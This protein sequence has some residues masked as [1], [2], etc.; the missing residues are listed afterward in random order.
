MQI[1]AVIECARA[2]VFYGRRNDN[3]FHTLAVVLKNCAAADPCDAVRNDNRAGNACDVN[4]IL[5]DDDKC[6]V[7]F[8]LL[9]EPGCECCDLCAD[10]GHRGRDAELFQCGAF[11][12]CTDINF[13]DTVRNHH[14]A[15]RFAGH[16]CAHADCF[17]GIRNR[18]FFQSAS[19]EQCIRN[20]GDLFRHPDCFQCRA[21]KECAHS[22][23]RDA[24]RNIH[25][26]DIFIFAEGLLVD[27]LHGIRNFDLARAGS[28]VNQEYSAVAANKRIFR[29]LCRKPRRIF[30]RLR[31]NRFQRIGHIDGFQRFAA[32]ER[33]ASDPRCLRRKLCLFQC[34]AAHKRIQRNFRN[35]FRQFGLLQ[36]FAVVECVW[37][38]LLDRIRNGDA[39]NHAAHK[40][41]CA[42]G[43]QTVRQGERPQTEAAVKR[44]AVDFFQRIRQMDLREVYAGFVN[45]CFFS[46]FR[47]RLS[48]DLCGNRDGC[49]RIIDGKR[50]ACDGNAAVLF[51]VLEVLPAF[52]FRLLLGTDGIA[53]GQ[54]RDGAGCC[55]QNRCEQCSMLSDFHRSCPPLK[56]S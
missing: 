54:C 34:I 38:D 20:S 46:D 13:C 30:Q 35:R 18:E 23:F 14:G 26:C 9:F 42:D 6:A 39:F 16:K 33:I 45:K 47:D 25:A 27:P 36:V 31:I 5:I 7:L 49:A 10:V 15:Q 44:I 53:C 43:F 55:Q 37:S 12:K 51:R 8:V 24:V 48:V 52:G 17:D 50:H 22:D 2:D 32:A 21:C 1:C 40:R 41:T 3:I 4:Q 19:V 11:Q 56:M 28:A 29:F